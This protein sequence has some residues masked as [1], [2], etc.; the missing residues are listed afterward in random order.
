[1]PCCR[2][3]WSVPYGAMLVIR[4]CGHGSRIIRAQ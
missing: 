1:M 2:L 4:T 3:A